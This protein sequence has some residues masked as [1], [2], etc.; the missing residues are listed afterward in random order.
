[1]Y[2]RLQNQIQ[3]CLP[4][5]SVDPPKAFI[6]SGGV[7]KYSIKVTFK[8]KHDHYYRADYESNDQH[9]TIFAPG[10][11]VTFRVSRYDDPK[12]PIIVVIEQLQDQEKK[13]I[14]SEASPVQGMSYSYALNQSALL[15]AA[16]KQGT[17][18]MLCEEDV[19]RMLKF[20]DMIDD[21]I[22]MKQE[23]RIT[24]EVGL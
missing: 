12:P 13:L 24:D 19:E 20:A 7:T 9:Q 4:V 22:I 23:Q 8:D 3:Y 14:L 17:L 21:W 5:I 10:N 6:A 1:M 16:E 11:M 18:N 15:L 2:K